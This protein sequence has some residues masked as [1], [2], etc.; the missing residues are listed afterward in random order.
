MSTEAEA[1]PV[2]TAPSAEAGASA[3]F[4]AS[5]DFD[6]LSK[7]V[8]DVLVDEGKIRIKPAFIRGDR[9]KKIAEVDQSA[10]CLIPVDS[11]SLLRHWL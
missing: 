5:W 3:T 6:A 8:C 2:V 4:D 1:T 10:C 9:E 7:A 11:S